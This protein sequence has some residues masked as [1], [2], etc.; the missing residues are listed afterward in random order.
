MVIKA[1]II[2]N[3]VIINFRVKLT[4]PGISIDWVSIFLVCKIR[5]WSAKL[6]FDKNSH[7][8]CGTSVIMLARRI[9]SPRLETV[10]RRANYP[11]H[12]HTCSP[13]VFMSA[14]CYF[15]TNKKKLIKMK[16]TLTKILT[17]MDC[18]K[19]N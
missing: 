17:K 9:N 10:Y 15:R 12:S 6:V 3:P 11:P 14:K 2:L 4:I 19:I 7:R 13:N 5:L 18:V 1:T 8:I 16:E